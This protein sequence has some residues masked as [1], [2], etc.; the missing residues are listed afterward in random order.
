MILIFTKVKKKLDNLPCK[1][2]SKIQIYQNS[3]D[4]LK[5]VMCIYIIFIYTFYECL[6][7]NA[8]FAHFLTG[9]E[10]IQVQDLRV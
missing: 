2:K 8:Q 4:C 1:F 6:S 3:T 7:A 5:L 10:Q 9:S